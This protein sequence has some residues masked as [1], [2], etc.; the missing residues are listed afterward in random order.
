MSTVD[1][2][3]EQGER[4]M[5][6]VTNGQERLLLDY[7]DLTPAEQAENDYYGAQDADYVRYRGTL[8]NVSDTEVCDAT[9]PRLRDMG[10]QSIHVD[11]FFSGVVFRYTDSDHVV[12]GLALV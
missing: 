8:Y 11:T 9:R 3:R 4:T 7:A 6:I 2:S 1:M 5:R 12:C 10:W